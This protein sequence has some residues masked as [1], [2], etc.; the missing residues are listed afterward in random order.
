MFYWVRGA[1]CQM[2]GRCERL[3]MALVCPDKTIGMSWTKKVWME[4]DGWLISAE[5]NLVSVHSARSSR[6]RSIWISQICVQHSEAAS[7]RSSIP[8]LEPLPI[9]NIFLLQKSAFSSPG[10][11]VPKREP[12]FGCICLEWFMQ[13]WEARGLWSSVKKAELLPAS[14]HV[15]QGGCVVRA[16]F[17]F[18]SGTCV[19]LQEILL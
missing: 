11:A 5:S 18:R 6:F 2:A 4:M 1:D 15:P 3:M 19:L 16:N 7:P 14:L 12:W 17:Y 10:S 9:A 13:L 8:A